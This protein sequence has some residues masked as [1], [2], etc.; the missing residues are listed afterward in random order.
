MM[1]AP[2]HGRALPHAPCAPLYPQTIS[3]DQRGYAYGPGSE[4]YS[5]PQ[6]PL[7]SPPQLI[8]NPIPARRPPIIRENINSPCLFP[9]QPRTSDSPLEYVLNQ[10]ART[11]PAKV[12]TKKVAECRE[13]EEDQEEKCRRYVLQKYQEGRLREGKSIEEEDVHPVYRQDYIV[14]DR[15]CDNTPSPH[16]SLSFSEDDQ[17]EKCRRYFLQRY[18]ED[19]LREGKSIEEEDIHPVYKQN[20]IVDDRSCGNTPGL[21]HSPSDS[22]SSVATLLT[23]ESKSPKESSSRWPPSA[24]PPEFLPH[25]DNVFGPFFGGAV[26][27]QYRDY[28]DDKPRWPPSAPSA[29]DLPPLEAFLAPTTYH[30]IPRYPDTGIWNIQTIYAPKPR[31]VQTMSALRAIISWGGD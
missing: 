18:Q 12:S 9:S 1:H 22:E 2:L 30:S 8:Y 6:A 26:Q 29:K 20:Y 4:Q 13:D 31:S 14:D 7:L 17:E 3:H 27:H 16:H 19:R 15:S 23:S 5:P 21:Y 11:E 25:P 24:P 28:H 10:Q